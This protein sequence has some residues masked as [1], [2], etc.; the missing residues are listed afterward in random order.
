M[1]RMLTRPVKNLLD[2]RWESQ[3]EEEQAQEKAAA[4]EKEEET[5]GK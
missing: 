4:E 3:E 1:L 5:K 2:S